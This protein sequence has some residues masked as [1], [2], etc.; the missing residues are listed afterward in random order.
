IGTRAGFYERTGAFRDMIVTHLF[1]VLGFVAMEPPTAL[2]PKPLVD[3]KVKVFASMMPL[4]REDV[5]RGQYDGYREEP[6]VAAGSQTET[7]IAVKA[8]VDNWRWTGVPF[9]LRTGK[10]LAQTRRVIT[11]GFRRPPRRMFDLGGAG[12]ASADEPNKLVID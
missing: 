8:F 2:L 3:E 12:G 1:Q 5:L 4:R 9:Y 11:L 6:G 7:F 10:R